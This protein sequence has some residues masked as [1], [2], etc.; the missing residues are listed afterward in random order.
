MYS[1]TSLL[2]SD[3]R[4]EGFFFKL[5]PIGTGIVTN[6]ECNVAHRGYIAEYK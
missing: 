3:N 6:I 4:R 1:L 2:E 5:A